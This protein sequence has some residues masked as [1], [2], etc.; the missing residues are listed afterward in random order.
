ML[1]CL[2]HTLGQVAGTLIF[3]QAITWPCNTPGTSQHTSPSHI[4]SWQWQDWTKPKSNFHWGL[5]QIRA[6][7]HRWI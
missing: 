6:K 3:T 2:S 4:V 5:C 7:G 1:A